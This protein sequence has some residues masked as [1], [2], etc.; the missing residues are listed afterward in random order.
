VYLF[1]LLSFLFWIGVNNYFFSFF[2]SFIF[3]L[4]LCVL[5]FQVLL[6]YYK[7]SFS[8]LILIF[9]IFFSFGAYYSEY[10]FW[11]K[12]LREEALSASFFLGKQVITFQVKELYSVEDFSKRYKVELKKLWEKEFIKNTFG[13]A[14]IPF[15]Y[16]IKNGDIIETEA[17]IYPIKNFSSFDYKNYL[18]SQDIYFRIYPSFIE[19]IWEKNPIFFLRFIYNF[20]EKLLAQIRTMYPKNEALYLGGILLWARESFSD[21]LKEEF[22]R[23]GLTHII[24]VS[25]FNI[26]I[27]IIFVSYIFSFFPVFV[28]RIGI[29]FFVVFFVC[30]VWFWA[31]VIRAALMGLLGFYFLEAGRK[32]SFAT[33]FLTTIFIMLL[34]EP[35]SLNYDMSF[36]LSFLAVLGIVVFQKTFKKIFFF[37]PSFF[38]LQESLVLTFS[39]FVF[40]L[41]LMLINFWSVSIVAPIS[42]MIV[43]PTIPFAMLF[44]FLSLIFSSFSLFLWQFFWFLAYIFLRL[45]M[46]VVHFFGTLPF[47]TFHISFSYFASYFLLLYYILLGWVLM[48]R[49]LK[50]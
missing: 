9:I 39:A 13:I 41:P 11:V 26:T 27:L 50:D 2:L 12:K 43:A 23:S 17:K 14:E 24:A 1:F 20:R 10:N 8:F 48:V 25:G 29:S 22:N 21:D 5:F 18:L 45:T 34:F 47:A 32:I 19:R 42:N 38:A 28:R 36:Q 46:E 15:N 37:V 6:F 7:R 40:T 35:L 3:V 33:L 31:P 30:L 49:R 4:L 16:D 44:W